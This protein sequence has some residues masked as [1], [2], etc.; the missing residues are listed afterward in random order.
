[1]SREQVIE[2]W[3]YCFGW[4][5]ETYERMEAQ[6][7]KFVEEHGESSVMNAICQTKRLETKNLG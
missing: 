3:D 6:V 4:E 5:H 2:I 1:M 7:E